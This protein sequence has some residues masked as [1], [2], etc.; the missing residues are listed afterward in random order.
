MEVRNSFRRIIACVIIFAMVLT[1]GG[2][3]TFA[4][5]ITNLTKK[6]TQEADKRKELTYKY[7][8]ELKYESQTL[9]LNNDG[10]DAD[11]SQVQNNITN[12]SD[13]EVTENTKSGDTE[14]GKVDTKAN[15][16]EASTRAEKMNASDENTDISDTDNSSFDVQNNSDENNIN[17]N[18]T[19]NTNKENDNN[20]NE[21]T[22]SDENNIDNKT[23]NNSNVNATNDDETDHKGEKVKGNESANGV[24]LPHKDEEKSTDSETKKVSSDSDAEKDEKGTTAGEEKEADDNN[25]YDENGNIVDDKYESDFE[26][27]VD[28]TESDA[29]DENA[30]NEENDENDTATESEATSDDENEG[31]NADVATDSE[32][33]GDDDIATESEAEENGVATESDAEDNEVATESDIYAENV[34]TDSDVSDATASDIEDI[35]IEIATKGE[36]KIASEGELLGAAPSPSMYFYEIKERSDGT[37]YTTSISESK[38][39]DYQT[40]VRVKWIFYQKPDTEDMIDTTVLSYRNVDKTIY[41]KNRSAVTAGSI[42]VVFDYLLEKYYPG[43]HKDYS[44][45]YSIKSLN[46]SE[47]LG[48][49]GIYFWNNTYWTNYFTTVSSNKGTMKGWSSYAADTINTVAFNTDM[50]ISGVIEANKVI[51]CLTDASGNDKISRTVDSGSLPATDEWSFA[52]VVQDVAPG[53]KL[54]EKT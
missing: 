31:E 52:E 3:S 8:K 24:T 1:S 33:A 18:T 25:L 15:T 32:A 4:A 47:Y 26:E 7:Y 23:G 45:D 14:S 2:V 53:T 51:Y 16:D 50:V 12:K 38:V 21:N 37:F 6:E 41:V 35:F 9:L 20:D 22:N 28:A 17:D 30:D 27:I 5:S 48:I 10:E 29:T 39:D 34:A 49:P 42:K 44:Y 54:S 13:V 36:A 43:Y 46:T 19:N 40:A 11:A